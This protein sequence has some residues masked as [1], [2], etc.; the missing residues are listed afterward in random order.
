MHITSAGYI[1]MASH[2]PCLCSLPGYGHRTVVHYLSNQKVNEVM[3]L[4]QISELP[5]KDC[6]WVVTVTYRQVKIYGYGLRVVTDLG[7]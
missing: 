5:T 6:G 7:D 2:V 4:D 1:T 3:F